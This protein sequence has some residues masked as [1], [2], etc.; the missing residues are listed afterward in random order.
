MHNRLSSRYRSDEM[1]GS[2]G[3]AKPRIL[4]HVTTVP[5]SLVFLKGQIGHM[6]SRGLRIHVLSSP[7]RDLESFAESENVPIHAVEMDRAITPIRDLRAVA[8][9]CRVLL[10]VKPT[11][12]H[13]HTP[14]G[15]LLGMIAAALMRVPVRVYH[16]RGLPMLTAKGPRRLLLKWTEKVAASLAHQ[17]LCNSHSMR[18]VVIAERICHRDKIKVL[19]GGSG[20]GVDAKVRFDPAVVDREARMKTRLELGIPACSTVIGFVGR[21]VLDKGIVE[22]VEAW[23]N[24]RQDYEQCH[25]LVVGPFELHDPVPIDTEQ[26]LREDPRIHLVGMVWNTP[27]LFAAMDLL[28]LPTHREGFPNVPLEAAAMELPVVATRIPGCIDAVEDSVTGTLVSA[29]D[30]EELANAIR[31]YL[32]SPALRRRHGLAGRKR[33]LRE[34]PQEAIWESLYSEYVRLMHDRG[35]PM[36]TDSE[37]AD[38]IL[39]SIDRGEPTIPDARWHH[40]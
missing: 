26:V 1:I 30:A 38:G 12:V 23:R 28:V 22:L 9:I 35:V 8:D 27:P 13:S 4:L 2:D 10:E 16:M 32:K 14:K 6:K 19:L 25:L 37:T 29:R 36:Q 7:G 11:I 31:M 5:M 20:N 3:E 18:E 17:V 34:F 24:I 39:A 33:V 21:V 15:G 40:E